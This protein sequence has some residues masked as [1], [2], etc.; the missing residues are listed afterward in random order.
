M[1]K[2]VVKDYSRRI[3]KKYGYPQ[4]MVH[5]VLMYFMRNVISSIKNGDDIRIPKFGHFYVD[6]KAFIN[7]F[8]KKNVNK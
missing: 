5:I 3:A 6:K 7:Y 4:W 2:R 8:K 1:E